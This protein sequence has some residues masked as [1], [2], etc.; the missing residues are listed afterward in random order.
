MEN[1]DASRWLALIGCLAWLAAT[2]PARGDDCACSEPPWLCTAPRLTGE[3][4][5]LRPALA[6][7]GLTFLADSTNFYFGN[8]AGGVQRQFDF[9]G[10]GDYVLVADGGKLWDREGFF[11]KLRAEHRYGVS[12]VDEVGTF[13][14]PTIA[15]DLPIPGSERLYLTNVLLTQM[16]SENFAVFAGKLD[17]LD[18]DMNAFAHGRGKTQFSNL[19]FVFNPIVAATVPYSTLG[20]GFIVFREGEPILTFTVFNS[21][22]TSG[23]SGFEQ[24]FNDG[25]LLTVNLRLPTNFLDRPGHH[26]F[27]ATWNNKTYASLG[28]AYVEYPNLVLPP[29][30]GSWSLFWNCDQY[31]VLDRDEPAHGWGAFARAGIADDN[32]SP[33]AWFLSF[34][35]GGNSPLASRPADTFG[36]GWYYAATSGQI[37]PVLET[38]F[39][40]IGNG[41]GVECFYNYQF[42]PAIRLTPDVQVLIPS[43]ELVEA[44]LVVGLRTQLI[45]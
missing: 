44:A 2:L 8:T 38:V 32:T 17:T 29:T 14:S 15:S 42:T 21:E 37:G 13:F 18:G 43:R 19:S 7:S 6:E 30:R 28:E 34:G 10:H 16:L 3:W 25:L 31:L 40:P 11:V 41:Q 9:S 35:L 20:A 33:L 36:V 4:G 45:F 5:G 39:G 24:L 26:L 12:I 23:T 1:M 22:D 27:G